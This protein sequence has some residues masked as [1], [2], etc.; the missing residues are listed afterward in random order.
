MKL[1]PYVKED[2]DD[3]VAVSMVGIY[4]ALDMKKKKQR[5][6][7]KRKKDAKDRGVRDGAQVICSFGSYLHMVSCADM[8]SHMQVPFL[9]CPLW[10]QARLSLHQ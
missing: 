2:A 7:C 10:K 4:A 6:D 8:P 5:K 9:I 1:T 3:A